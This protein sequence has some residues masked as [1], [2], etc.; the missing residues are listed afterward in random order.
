MKAIEN[1]EIKEFLD[2]VTGEIAFDEARKAVRMEIRGHL[3]DHIET[4]KSYGFANVEAIRD[5]I[6]RMGE[7]HEIGRSLNQVHR[8]K[9][10]F[11]LMTL[12]LG[13][14]SVGLW[15]LSSTKWIGSQISWIVVGLSIL[16]SLYFSSATTIRNVLSSLY[17][18]A[19]VGL[20]ASYFSGVTADGQPYL[21][22]AGL[23]IK[24]VDLSAVLFSLGIPALSSRTSATRFGMLPA[25]ILFL[26]PLAYFS[27]NGFIWSGLLVL[28]SGLCF[29]GMQKISNILFLGVGLAGTGLL[30][31]KFTDGIA[32]MTEVN[33]AIVENAHTDY[34]LHSLSAAIGAE[35]F[36]AAFLIALLMYGFRQV[37]TIKESNLRSLAVVAISLLAVQI[38][39]SVFANLGI[40]PMI[41][42]GVNIPFVSYGGSGIIANFLIVAI[43]MACFKRKS[44]T[45][46]Y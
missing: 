37:L 10:D 22:F 7:P 32:P 34:A 5:S 38:V 15:N 42:A 1:S 18:L 8:P 25:I 4:A 20:A 16:L 3:E 29:L 17:A 45:L 28:V 41:S 14:C 46:A 19:I 31:S 9:F 30:L 21:S 11:I 40:L 2:N 13:L 33:K 26:V 39:V 23:N 44:L 36:A 43:L 6:K 24:I 27:L 12:C 35:I